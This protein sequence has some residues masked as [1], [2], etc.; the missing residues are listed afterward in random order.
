MNGYRDKSKF[1]IIEMTPEEAKSL[2]FGIP[3]GCLCMH[4]N[5]IIKDTI[6]YIAVLNDVMDIHCL[7]QYLMHAKWY[8]E[9]AMIEQRN[10]YNI[11][12]RSKE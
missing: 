10:F 2:G 9:D 11:I 3:E 8:P 5:E 6:Y 1:L 12:R 4:C 7:E